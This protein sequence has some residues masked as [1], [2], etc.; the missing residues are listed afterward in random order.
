[1]RTLEEID[2]DIAIAREDARS[3]MATVKHCCGRIAK[4]GPDSRR[5]ARAL[6]RSDGRGEAGRGKGIAS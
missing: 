5:K 4:A 3:G 1:M 2:R 6:H